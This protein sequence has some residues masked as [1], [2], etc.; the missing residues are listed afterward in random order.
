MIIHKMSPLS[1]QAF[2]A[3]YLSTCERVSSTREQRLSTEFTSVFSSQHQSGLSEVLSEDLA[4]GIEV[5]ATKQPQAVFTAVTTSQVSAMCK[6]VSEALTNN[7]MCSVSE[8][9]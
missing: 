7:Q 5:T 3:D 8:T 2:P 1:Q 9:L 6:L 4:E